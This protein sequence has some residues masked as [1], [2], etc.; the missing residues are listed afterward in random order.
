MI[1]L[2]S[3]HVRLSIKKN[4]GV[5]IGERTENMRLRTKT[6][7]NN[8]WQEYKGKMYHS[9]REARYARDLDLRVKAKEIREWNTQVKIPLVVNKR[10]ICS[11]IA[12]FVVVNNDYSLEIHEVKGVVTPVFRIKWKLLQALF[13]DQYEYV[14]ITE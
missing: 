7:Y 5:R 11:Y 3:L 10:K 14:L 6:K 4:T 12:D 9:K 1:R 13:G 2:Q 8:V